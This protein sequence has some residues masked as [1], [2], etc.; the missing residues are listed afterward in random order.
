[1]TLNSTVFKVIDYILIIVV[2]VAVF[3]LANNFI[4]N[5]AID[6]CAQ[7]YRYSAT[8]AN[9]STVTYPMTTEYK[10]CLKTKGIK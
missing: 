7:S 4:K 9:G 6:G 10:E 8:L 2:V 1:M 3:F 5:Q